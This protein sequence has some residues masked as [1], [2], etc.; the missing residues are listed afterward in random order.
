[1]INLHAAL[2]GDLRPTVLSNGILVVTA[3]SWI[4]VALLSVGM[5]LA[6]RIDKLR[7]ARELDGSRRIP[8]RLRLVARSAPQQRPRR[9]LRLSTATAPVL[10]LTTLAILVG[11]GMMTPPSAGGSGGGPVAQH[12]PAVQPAGQPATVTVTATADP[13]PAIAAPAPA[14]STHTAV[15]TTCATRPSPTSASNTPVTTA[16]S[17]TK[18]K[19]PKTPAPTTNSASST[20]TT[21]STQTD[22]S[23][24]RHGQ[25]SND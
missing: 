12:G 9:H 24:S 23:G 6:A 25:A 20:A 7:L 21:G 3:A 11:L 17:T 18:T 1:L 14:T 10:L 4:T 8:Q 15:P 22:A 16:P 13:S 2:T 5:S 19:R